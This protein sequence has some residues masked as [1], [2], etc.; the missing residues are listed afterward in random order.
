MMA[1]LTLHQN[2]HPSQYGSRRHA[3][4]SKSRASHIEN[5][6]AFET[7]TP[8]IVHGS[9][10]NAMAPSLVRRSSPTFVAES[11]RGSGGALYRSLT[12]PHGG[13]YNTSEQRP[14]SA[15]GRKKNHVVTFDHDENSESERPTGKRSIK[16]LLLRSRSEHGLRTEEHEGGHDEN[17][18]HA[19]E[20]IYNWGT[21]HGF[22]D[23]YQSEDIIS[24]LANVSCA[25]LLPI[26]PSSH[27]R[28][29]GAAKWPR[30]AGTTSLSCG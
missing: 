14:S 28:V 4:S 9:S 19:E 23:T 13:A 1:A 26:D 12:A 8:T 10:G 18:E 17:Q 16:P 3:P 24:Q 7:A 11:G 25:F 20:E 2:A 5:P 22:E 30:A 6:H 29:A 15:P 21:R 27:L